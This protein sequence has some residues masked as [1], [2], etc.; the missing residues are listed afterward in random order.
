MSVVG[1]LVKMNEEI[2]HGKTII[3]LLC[4]RCLVKLMRGKDSNATDIL[5]FNWTSLDFEYRKL[6]LCSFDIYH[7]LLFRHYDNTSRWIVL[8]TTG[9]AHH[10]EYHRFWHLF[11]C[12]IQK[13]LFNKLKIKWVLKSYA[14]AKKRFVIQRKNW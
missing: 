14:K 6:K 8:L 10:L 12:T 2:Y 11:C 4:K 9:S 7:I 5:E 13:S 1:F 3:F